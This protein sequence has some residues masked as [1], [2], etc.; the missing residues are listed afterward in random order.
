MTEDPSALQK[1]EDFIRAFMLG[2]DVQD[3]I[4][5]LRLDELYLDSFE[6]TDGLSLSF[7]LSFFLSPST[8]IYFD[9]Y[10]HFIFAALSFYF[11]VDVQSSHCRE[12]TCRVRLVVLLG[13][14]G[15]PSSQ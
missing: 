11:F 2:F 10:S 8:C 7:L 12:I 6:I 9:S 15:G 1:A 4:A 13:S 3:A 14:K 5:L